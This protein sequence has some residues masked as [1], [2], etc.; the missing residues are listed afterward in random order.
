VLK[1]LADETGGRSFFVEKAEELGPVYSAI[2]KELR[3]RYLLA[4]QSTNASREM[5]F[6]AVEVQVDRPGLEAKTMRGYYP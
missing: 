1:T 3:S 4:Y 2:Q 5:R 6:R